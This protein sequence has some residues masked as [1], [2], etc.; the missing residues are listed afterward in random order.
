VSA[1]SQTT[2]PTIKPEGALLPADLLKRLADNDKNL[3]G[4]APDSYHLEKTARL[5]EAVNRAW[6]DCRDAWQRFQK[7]RADIQANPSET[8]VTVT[9]ERWLLR[10]FETLGYGRLQTSRSIDIDGRSYPVSHVWSHSPFL[11]TSFKYDLDRAQPGVFRSSPHSLMQ[12]LL[13]RSDEYMWGFASNGLQ[14]RI[15]RDN[16]SFTRSAYVEFDLEAMMDGEVYADFILLWL[17]C[18][19]SRVEGD[20]PE[21]CWLEKWHQAAKQQGT[22]ALDRLRDGVEKAIESLGQGFLAHRANN[23]LRQKLRDGSLTTPAYY[24]QL[25]R[26]VYRFIFLFVAEDRDLLFAPN[27]DDTARQL[28]TEHYSLG[29]IRRIAEHR[30]GTRHSDLWHGVRLVLS[31]L[32]KGEPRLGLPGLGSWLFSGHST[33]DLDGCD[34]R[35]DHLLTAVRHL[36]FTQDRNV[37]RHVDYKNLGSEELGSVYESLLELQPQIHA[38]AATFELSAVIGSERKTTGS[39]YTPSSLIQCLLDS[40]LDPV[41]EDRL[42][43]KSSAGAEKALLSLKICDPACGSGHFL[44]AAA[45]RVAKRLAAIRTG[46]DEPSPTD[47]RAAFRDVV[48]HCIYGVDINPMAVE[49]CKVALWLESIDPGRPLSFLDHRILCGNSLIGATPR[50]LKEGVPDDAFKPIEGDDK[51]ICSEYKRRNKDERKGQM[52]FDFGAMPSVKLGNLV[53]TFATLVA[54]EDGTLG[55]VETKARRYAEFVG[56]TGYQS[57]RL[58]ADAWCAAFVWKKDKTTPDCITESWL[59][60]IEA[61]PHCLPPW[62]KAEIARLRDQYQIF[63]WVLAF[64]DVFREPGANASPE[65]ERTGWSGG[66]D[67]V[68]GNPPWGADVP[69]RSTSLIR[70]RY[71]GSQKGTLDTFA[72]FV[73]LFALMTRAGQTLGLVLP[74]IVLLKNYPGIRLFLLDHTAMVEIAHWG[75]AFDQVNIDVCSLVARRSEPGTDH[76]VRCI[77]EVIDGQPRASHVNA[78]SQSTFRE[79]KQYRFNLLLSPELQSLISVARSLGPPMSE[80][81]ILREGAHSGNVRSKLFIDSQDGDQCERLI[82]GRDEI[83][84]MLLTWAGRYIQLDATCFDRA[85]GEYFN[86][87]DPDL[88][89]SR[90]I[91]VRRT[92]DHLLAAL[93]NDG[94]FCSNNFFLCVAKP[95]VT[96]ERVLYTCALLNSRFATWF[97]RAIQP[98]TGKLFAE[99]KITHLEDI[100]VLFA[101]EAWAVTVGKSIEAWL[102]A[103]ATIPDLLSRFNSD[104]ESR[105]A[106]VHAALS[107]AL[108]GAQ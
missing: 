45:N 84:P 105:I 69:M 67:V 36:A 44:I 10:L 55:D 85:A 93:D 101:N 74:D 94:L 3:D 87:G 14:L 81:F 38:D 60:R 50:L 34:L 76:K 11:L 19:Q 80:L 88:H 65:N 104:L 30:R 9:R 90:K 53:P 16:V 42:K 12:E 77:P 61:N 52:T 103:P 70:H 41:M 99:L 96:W 92:G 39:Y 5:T 54:V 64:L 24:Q 108:Q 6:T 40:A 28:Y 91:L 102:S 35:N 89:R 86:L 13:N 22:R 82:F 21:Q 23:D 68:F 17:L 95:A 27:A 78:I 107:A 18:H 1:R 56:S 59:R 58:L 29:R 57:A 51:A 71:S 15:L 32:Y 63:P 8:G 73:E 4:L 72:L 47:Q 37:L 33:P 2:F 25:L 66:F 106:S 46:D 79:T 26:L 75:Q 100:P 62:M 48:S 43:G 98:R 83:S 97:F 7:H 31:R 20:P 49:L